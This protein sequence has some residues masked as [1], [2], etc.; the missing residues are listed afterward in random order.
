MARLRKI[1]PRGPLRRAATRRRRAPELAREEILTAAERVYIEF[2]PDQVGL[3]DIAREADVSHALIT[4]YFGTYA[5]LVEATLERRIRAL[6]EKILERLREVGV[7]SRPGELLE[8]LFRALEDPIH[9]R[10]TRWLLASERPGA[11]HAFALRDHGLQLVAQQVAIALDPTP[12]PELV[13][14]IELALL[15]AV[16][17]AYG[18]AIGKYPLVTALG[19]QA[20]HELDDKVH[21]TLAA[22][23][24]AHLRTEILAM[25][26]TR[27]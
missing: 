10:L 26:T 22:M 6:R 4:H 24:Q 19:R 5:G 21:A 25:V 2:Q 9:L 11:T 14:K 7:L 15:C 20:S 17:A 3:K 13:A 16:S 23:V 27:A 1:R 12:N 8:L 18:Y